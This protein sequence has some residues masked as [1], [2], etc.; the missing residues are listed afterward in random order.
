MDAVVYNTED[1]TITVHSDGKVTGRVTMDEWC[2][3]AGGFAPVDIT[4]TSLGKLLWAAAQSKF[5]VKQ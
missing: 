3:V 4:D 1:F 5:G 2:P